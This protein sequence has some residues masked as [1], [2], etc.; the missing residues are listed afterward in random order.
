MLFIFENWEKT[1]TIPKFSAIQY[2]FHRYI[3]V[4]YTGDKGS[5]IANKI[6]EGPI[7]TTGSFRP[8]Q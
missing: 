7:F 2:N 5:A 8:F 1:F 3:R 4:N 6:S